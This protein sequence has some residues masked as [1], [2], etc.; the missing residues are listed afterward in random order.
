[1]SWMER[2]VWAVYD[3]TATAMTAAGLAVLL[4]FAGVGLVRGFMKLID[5][6][7]D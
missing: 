1:M 3:L 2:V 6:T 7:E 4:F 5:E